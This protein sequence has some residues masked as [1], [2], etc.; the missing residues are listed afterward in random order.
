MAGC[1]AAAG[2]GLLARSEYERK[3]FQT[4]IYPIRSSRLPEAFDGYR[5]IFLAD[6]HNHSFGPENGRLLAA[7]RALR[8]DCV[9][10]GGDMVVA[11]GPKSLE[12]PLR[13]M[14]AL[15]A[16]YP[17]YYGLGNHEQRM[18]REREIYGNQYDIY[19]GA[20]KELGVHILR[21]RGEYIERQGSCIRVDGLDLD[22]RFYKKVGKRPMPPSWLEKTLGPGRIGEYRI[23]LAHSPLYFREYVRWGADLVL[24]GHFHGGTIRL[25]L[26]GGVMT[27]NYM[28][29]PEYDRGLYQA[30]EEGRRGAMIL[31]A[32]LGTHSINIRLNNPPQ[33]ILV[34][35]RRRHG[36]GS[37]AESV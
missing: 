37:K 14:E 2:A 13:L 22:R 1:S 3:H 35:L 18:D 7:I 26:L 32:G 19:M 5:I 27:P 34:E 6:L 15:A 36:T 21:N 31:S 12:V 30:R 28:F 23:L 24:A 10:V 9:M 4:D 8:P 11:K 16:D 25:P 33:L 29:F 17:V 20:L